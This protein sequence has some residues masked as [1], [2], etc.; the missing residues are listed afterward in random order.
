VY[1]VGLNFKEVLF[2]LGMLP[3][4]PVSPSSPSSPS[5]QG[6][7]FTFGLECSGRITSCGAGVDEFK[8]G[9]EVI[10]FASSAFS[11]YVVVP[12]ASAA[13]KP[14]HLSFEESA[15]IP[16]AFMTAY[17]S[18]ITLG[19]LKKGERVLIHSAAGGVGLAAVKIAQWLGAEIFATAGNPAKRQYLTSLGIQQVMDSR[20][21]GFA[22]E[23]AAI[24]G[25]KGVDVVLNSLPGEAIL[26]GISILAPHGRFLELGVR[27]IVDNTALGMRVFEKS[28]SFSAVSIDTT[29]PG[30]TGIFREVVDHINH[31][32]FE[33]LPCKVFPIEQAAG[34]FKYMA[35]AKHIGKIV[36][37]RPYRRETIGIDSGISG[38]NGISGISGISPAEGIDVLARVLNREDVFIDP[39]LSQIVVST[40]DF[41]ARIRENQK[42]HSPAD[43]AGPAAAKSAEHTGPRSPRPLLSTDFTPP[44]SEMEKRLAVVWEEYLGLDRVGIHDNF[45]E[46]GASSLDIIQVN[47]KLNTLLGKELSLVAFYTYPTIHSLAMH[48]D[49][50]KQSRDVSIKEE[51]NT[52]ELSKS[53]KTLKNTISKMKGFNHERNR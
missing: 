9:D 38:I 12:A 14:I 28:I 43:E 51:K 16:I 25:G 53:Q 13:G 34:A 6:P 23:I 10:A 30:F 32:H 4:P 2:A 11:R 31:R 36:V 15:A 26:K 45:F 22:G 42:K 3:L 1:A 21:T 24:T 17:Y 52:A 39:G 5:S 35:Q 48:L 8:T 18:L 37:S 47:H 19:R 27:D 49:E 33:P 29:A 46:L 7:S 40:W 44:S 20:S 50:A 41:N